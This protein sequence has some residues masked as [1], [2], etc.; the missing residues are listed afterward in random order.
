ME[1][2]S[3]ALII[4][5]AILLSIAIIGIGMYVFNIASSTMQDTDMSAEQAAAYNAKFLSYEGVKNGTTVKT[6]INTV[7]SHNAANSADPTK[8]IV[9][10]S[11]T[12][13]TNSSG[14][15]TSANQ[16]AQ[17]AAYGVTN[18]SIV[19]G[20]QYTISIGYSTTGLVKRIGIVV[21]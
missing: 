3:K 7:R 10:V 14:T 21:K 4:A 18:A 5:G 12:A 17:A 6:L 2:A 1:N 9:I 13:Q 20:R 15:G 16:D 19:S 8:Q 11:G